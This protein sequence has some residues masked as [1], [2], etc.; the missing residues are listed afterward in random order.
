MERRRSYMCPVNGAQRH[1]PLLVPKYTALK[2]THAVQGYSCMQW[3][4]PWLYYPDHNLYLILS[5]KV[6]CAWGWQRLSVVD[7]SVQDTNDF[8]I[9]QSTVQNKGFWMDQ[10]QRSE[11]FWISMLSI[12]LALGRRDLSGPLGQVG[13]V[14]WRRSFFSSAKCQSRSI[15]SINNARRQSSI[16]LF[17]K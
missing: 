8:P 10:S 9:N 4:V 13:R 12:G 15:M 6:I 2:K 11:R 3:Q 1:G 16:F 17:R 7:Y 5:P 14:P